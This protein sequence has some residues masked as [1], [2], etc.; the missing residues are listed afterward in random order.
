VALFIRLGPV[1]GA[2]GLC[3]DGEGGGSRGFGEVGGVAAPQRGG[4]RFG[5]TCASRCGAERSDATRWQPAR[6]STKRQ[7]GWASPVQ[8]R[9]V[10]GGVASASPRHVVSR[11]YR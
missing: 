10:K 1:H 4:D 3:T 6:R 2:P 9:W 11:A 5:A 7:G 8:R